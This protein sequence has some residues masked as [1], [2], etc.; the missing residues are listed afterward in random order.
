VD[1]ARIYHN[2]MINRGVAYW[3][4]AAHANGP[5]ARRVLLATL[6]MQLWALDA[7]TGTPCSGFGDGGRVDL[8]AGLDAVVDPVEATVTSPPTFGGD[9]V[10]VGSSIADEVRRRAPPGDVRGLDVRTGRR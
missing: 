7:S 1:R 6:S 10:V 4:D 2:L 8:L 3:R 5:C 9:V